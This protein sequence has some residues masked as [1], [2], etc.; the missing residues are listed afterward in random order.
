MNRSKKT[1]GDASILVV[2]PGRI[3]LSAAVH[4]PARTSGATVR[5]RYARP[6]WI[7]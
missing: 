2:G 1:V 7:A 6:F 3:F 5:R 4:K